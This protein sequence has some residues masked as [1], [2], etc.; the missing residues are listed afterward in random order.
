M[1]TGPALPLVEILLEE[2]TRIGDMQF[3][4][5]G[6]AD[7]VEH[8]TIHH[9]AITTR[10]KPIVILFARIVVIQPTS[11]H[12]NH[13]TLSVMLPLLQTS[14]KRLDPLARGHDCSPMKE[15]GKSNQRESNPQPDG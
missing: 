8:L 3:H 14:V 1:L 10:G 6:I 4:D 5:S 15:K 11:V 9:L 7:F 2:T 13:V 12:R